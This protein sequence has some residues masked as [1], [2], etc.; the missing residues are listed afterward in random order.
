MTQLTQE[1]SEIGNT[2]V[3]LKARLRMWFITINNYTTIEEDIIKNDDTKVYV[4]QCEEGE[5]KTPHIHAFLE[6]KNARFF[7]AMKKKYPRAHILSVRN[8][9]AVIKYCSKLDTRVRGF[10]SKG[11]PKEIE[12]I[13]E[14]RDWQKQVLAILGLKPDNRTIHWYYDKIGKVGKTVFC[15]YLCAKKNALYLSGKASDAKYLISQHV[16]KDSINADNLICLFDLTRSREKYV[17][18]QAIEEIKNGIFMSTK[19]ECNMLIMN[20]P[21][22]IIFANFEPDKTRL[23]TDRWH[24]TNLSPL[25]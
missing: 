3:N 7:G 12:L 4:Y 10:Y 19:Y 18:Y 2:I 21:H 8:R 16:E 9:E 1:E 20:C 6:Y 23:S 24:I 14:F 25:P 17:S 5:E 22:V 13:T 11:L 15:K